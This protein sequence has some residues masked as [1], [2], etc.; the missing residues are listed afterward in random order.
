MIF[1]YIALAVVA[2]LLVTTAVMFVVTFYSPLTKAQYDV[3]EVPTGQGYDEYRDKM[4]AMIDELAAYKVETVAIP[5]ADGLVLLG[6][7][8]HVADGAPL[9]IMVHGYRGLAVRDFSGGA[10][11]RI[12]NGHNVLLVEQ[13]AHEHSGGHVITFGIRERFDVMRWVDYAVRRFGNDVKI[14][15]FGVSMGAA[16]VLMTSNL[17]LPPQVKA[18]CADC[19]YSSPADII[20]NTIHS[21][22]LPVWLCYPLVWLGALVW[23]HFNLS[24]ASAVK[25]VADAT[26][27]IL[28]MHGMSDGFVPCEMSKK[29]ASANP[30]KVELHLWSDAV[31]A[32]SFVLHT[33][34]YMAIEKAFLDKV[35]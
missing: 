1:V 25:A 20:K 8:I 17:G 12:K 21:L 31:H 32:M 22:K 7:Y 9:D 23:G 29:I 16:T 26:I 14:V 5:S 34:D 6:K 19:P 28:I 3:R 35:L 24:S 18:I 2:L 13:R 11:A 30:D 10:V 4:L 15:L 33:D 27:P